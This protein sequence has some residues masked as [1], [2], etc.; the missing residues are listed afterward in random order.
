MSE[1]SLN[2]GVSL[3]LWASSP[4]KE[5][6]RLQKLVFPE[7]IIYDKEKGAF[8]TGR[9][10]SVFE[11]IAG[12]QQNLDQKEKGQT[13]GKTCLSLSAEREGFEPPDL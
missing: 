1:V 7:G 3:P 9:V 8:R 4:V 2:H 11:L 12:L 6:E 10:N 13:G 5:K